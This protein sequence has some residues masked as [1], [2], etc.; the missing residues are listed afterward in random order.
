MTERRKQVVLVTGASSGIGRACA[1]RLAAHGHR[2]FGTTRQPVETVTANM[3]AT[4]PHNADLQLFGMNV[5]DPTSVA[6][7]VE[8]VLSATDRLDAVINC[9]GFGIGGATEA[10][11]DT[12]AAAI[13]ETNVFGVVRVCRAVLPFL[14]R[15]GSGILINVSSI[16]GRIGL[17]YQGFYSATKFALEGLTEAL[18]MEVRSFGVR[19][20]LVE[21]GD[22]CTGFTDHRRVVSMPGETSPYAASQ[23]HVLSIVERDERGG[24]SPDAVARLVE[25]ILSKRSPKVRYTVGPA[26][27]RLAAGLKR[28]LPSKWFERALL[29]YY[30][31]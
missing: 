21:P 25:R 29:W 14:R 16:G 4:L 5:D 7:G 2:V 28:V 12:D 8:A 26:A 30:G 23:E 31:V 13:F 19:V 18:R 3:R 24:G 11:P 15:Q 6:A 10:T 9:A 27:Q 17:P 22:F 20:V 1:L